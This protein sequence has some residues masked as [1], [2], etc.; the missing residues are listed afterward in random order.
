MGT[1]GDG[2]GIMKLVSAIIRPVKLDEVIAALKAIG[3]EEFMEST[4]ICHG[5]RK[6][7]TILYRGAECVANFAEKVK[8]EIVAADD[9]VGRVVE[10][11][12]SIAKTERR[13]D[14]CIYI[15]QFVQA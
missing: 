11:I 10:A 13:A 3:I 2:G 12:G 5:R 15:L 14:C 4:L 9:A 8:L 7:Q 1:K 6:G